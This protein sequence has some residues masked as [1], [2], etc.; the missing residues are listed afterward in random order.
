MSNTAV[1]RSNLLLFPDCED[2]IEDR[3]STF[4]R[5]H[6][7]RSTKTRVSTTTSILSNETT[8]RGSDRLDELQFVL[9]LQGDASTS[10]LEQ[11]DRLTTLASSKVVAATTSRERSLSCTHSSREM[12]LTSKPRETPTPAVCFECCRTSRFSIRRVLTTQRP[13]RSCGFS[14]TA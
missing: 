4:V 6:R 3:T 10:S 5:K 9:S 2:R 12:A 11:C 8:C 1:R 7:Q 14:A 13:A